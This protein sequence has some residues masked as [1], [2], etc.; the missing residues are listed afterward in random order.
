MLERISRRI[1]NVI[2]ELKVFFVSLPFSAGKI[3]VQF[4]SA[5]TGKKAVAV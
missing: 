3:E 2:L 4:F 1:I 5:E